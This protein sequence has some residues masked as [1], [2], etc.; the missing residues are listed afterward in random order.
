MDLLPWITIDSQRQGQTG[1]FTAPAAYSAN[2][3]QLRM[4]IRRS[5]REHPYHIGA[6]P[7]V[8]KHLRVA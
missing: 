1:P 7:L 5:V 6:A 4:Y 2:R 8:E 3:K